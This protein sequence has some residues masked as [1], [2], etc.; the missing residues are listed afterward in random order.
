MKRVIEKADKK[1]KGYKQQIEDMKREQQENVKKTQS[2]TS[3]M[4]NNVNFKNVS[5]TSSMLTTL[6]QHPAFM[7]G[8]QLPSGLKEK[9]VVRFENKML[10]F[11]DIDKYPSKHSSN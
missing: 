2:A 6:Q 8:V 11:S 7:S 1:I 3:T 10:M 4:D 5:S 9:K